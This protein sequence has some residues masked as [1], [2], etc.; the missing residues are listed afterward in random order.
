VRCGGHKSTGGQNNTSRKRLLHL[1]LGGRDIPI[2][3]DDNGKL[4]TPRLV[5]QD[6]L[7][8]SKQDC[9]NILSNHRADFEDHRVRE[10]HPMQE[11][12]A[13]DSCPT[14]RVIKSNPTQEHRAH[15]A[16]H[17]RLVK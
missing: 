4:M 2:I 8:I 5:V 6:V 13:T 10:T 9:Q 12:R 7:G 11:L 15:K 16:R 3:E 14:D 17:L 1:Q